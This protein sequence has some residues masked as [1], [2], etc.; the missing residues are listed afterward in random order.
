MT[1]RFSLCPQC[2]ACPEVI[3]DGPQVTI[4]EPGN[5]ARLSAAEWNVLVRAVRSGA[6]REVD[7]PAGGSEAGR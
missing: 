4:G 3:I 5:Q 2:D 1:T 7:G 6:L